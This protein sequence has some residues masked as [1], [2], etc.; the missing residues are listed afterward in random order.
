MVEVKFGKRFTEAV[1][2]RPR[3]YIV[4]EAEL[5]IVRVT[6]VVLVLKA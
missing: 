1:C 5:S 6:L 4:L 2:Q 3:S